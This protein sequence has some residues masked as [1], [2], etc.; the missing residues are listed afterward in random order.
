MRFDIGRSVADDLDYWLDKLMRGEVE[1]WQF[2]PALGA[3]F[4]AGEIAGAGRAA[5][6][7]EPQLN[8]LRNQLAHAEYDRDRYFEQLH[9]PGRRFT[10]MVARRIDQAAEANA[11][12]VD[13]IKYYAAVLEAATSPR[14]AA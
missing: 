2:H 4:M 8:R 11:N 12:E 3:W 6:R 14:K 13:A 9:N 10:D 1:I 5:E 7:Y